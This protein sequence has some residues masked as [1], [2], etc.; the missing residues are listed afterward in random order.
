[1]K[2][3]MSIGIIRAFNKNPG[4]KDPWLSNKRNSVPDKK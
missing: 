1:M 4:R 2:R 3:I